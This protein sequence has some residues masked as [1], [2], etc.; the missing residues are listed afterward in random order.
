[1]RQ[2]HPLSPF[3]SEQKD[4]LEENYIDLEKMIHKIIFI[5][6]SKYGGDLDE[7]LSEAQE[8]FLRACNTYNEQQGKLSTHVYNHVK[9]GLHEV[10][11]RK[12]KRN[13]LKIISIEEI[14]SENE[15]EDTLDLEDRRQKEDLPLL[16]SEVG[17]DCKHIIHLIFFPPTD[18]HEEFQ[19]YSKTENYKDCLKEYLH[20]HMKWSL[21]R[22]REAFVE[23]REA[24]IEK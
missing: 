3:T 5:H 9:N 8:K 16:L 20:F 24:L 13:K 22:I 12:G 6:I 2:S 15:D 23:L 21:D 4:L 17:E 10:G 11:R 14:K 1:M 18:L 19:N 7:L